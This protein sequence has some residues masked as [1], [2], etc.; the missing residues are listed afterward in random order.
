MNFQLSYPERVEGFKDRDLKGIPNKHNQFSGY[1]LIAIVQNG[2]LIKERYVCFTDASLT[3]VWIEK[4]TAISS[5]AWFTVEDLRKID[6][7][8]EFN[9][10]LNFLRDKKI[11]D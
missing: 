9:E 6:D 2:S 10:V 5:R 8:I 11:L 4:V 7:D 1:Y 3:Q